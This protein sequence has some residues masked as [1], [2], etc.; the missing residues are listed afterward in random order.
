MAFIPAQVTN[1]INFFKMRSASTGRGAEL[2]GQDAA[3]L[4]DYGRYLRSYEGFAIRGPQ[5]STIP[6]EWER[7]RFNFSRPIVNLGAGF[8]AGKPIVWSVDVS[9]EAQAAAHEIWDRSGSDAMMLKA[10]TTCGI[11]GDIVAIAAVD[12]DGQPRIEFVDPCICFP[13]F[14]GADYDRLA[15]LEIAYEVLDERGN[16][17]LRREFYGPASMTIYVGD[18]II[19]ERTYDRIPAVWIRNL[20]IKGRPFGMSDLDGVVD[21]VEAYDHLASK[22]TRI[23][24]YY[25]APTI[26]FK[27]VLPGTFNKTEKTAIYLAADGDAGFIEWKGNAPAIADQ[28]DRIRNAIAEVSQVPAVAF[29]QADSGLTQISGVALQILYGPLINKTALKHASWG[30]G[31]EEIMAVALT[32]AGYPVNT[33]DVDVN[34]PSG[35]PV[36]GATEAK[37]EGDKVASGLQST[38]TAMANLGVEDPAGEL[39][40]ILVEKILAGLVAAATAPPPAPSTDNP[41]DGTDPAEKPV[42]VETPE[43]DPLVKVAEMLDLF[44]AIIAAEQASYDANRPEEK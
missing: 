30:P 7:I 37:E 13:T 28:M 39:K 11:Y 41:G 25:A 21:L 3:R 4:R 17:S 40:R 1:L 24:D 44:D 12:A 38:R 43:V 33:T 18:T 34:W 31:L 26:Y 36:D 9:P 10:A 27:G 15:A 19:E 16:K 5:G 6:L 20:S 22:Q 14:D 2:V 29:G 23:V 8:L 42:P 35:L 32:A